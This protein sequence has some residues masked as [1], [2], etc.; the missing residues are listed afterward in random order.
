[1]KDR[2]EEI[3]S[4]GGFEGGSGE[5]V[6]GGGYPWRAARSVGGVTFIS[7]LGA[8][9]GLVSNALVAYHFGAG[10]LTDAFFLA[11]S[12]PL[13]L[14][15]LLQSGPLPSVFLPVFLRVRKEV[16]AEASWRLLSSLLN[17]VLLLD[18]GV[19][20]LG[21]FLAPWIVR[22]VGAGF[23]EATWAMSVRVL[24]FLIFTLVAHTL[25]GVLVIS[26]NALNRFVLPAAFSLLPSLGVVLFVGTLAPSMGLDAWIL[27]NLAGPAAFL[28]ALGLALVR[29]GYRYR[30]VLDLRQPEFLETVRRV[31]QFFI[32]SAFTQGQVLSTK[33][34]ASLLAPGSLSALAYAERIFLAASALFTIPLPNVVFPE[35]VRRKVA[36]RLD[37]LRELLFQASR[38]LVLILLPIS[39]GMMTIG[40]LVVGLLLQRGAFGAEDA[41]RTTWSLVLYSTALVPLGYKMLFTNTQHAFGRTRVVVLGLCAAQGTIIVGNFLF[42]WLFDYLGIPIAHALGQLVL[43]GVHVHFLKGSFPLKGI[44]WSPSSRRS[45]TAAVLMGAAALLFQWFWPAG[46]PTA[47]WKAS[48]LMGAVGVSGVVYAGLVFGLGVPEVQGVV[49]QVRARLNRRASGPAA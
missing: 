32:S 29:H 11:Q 5:D 15:H 27:G 7:G 47:L 38:A 19:A 26:L 48:V 34:V 42:A 40:G 6:E 43:I 13:V 22:A 2:P 4:A 24:R 8:V 9:L 33:F 28:L 17:F 18:V 41:V 30:P 16:S 45:L 31:C 10:R 46:E 44:F 39:I 49:A 12:I 20:A 25:S 35:L 3:L 21:F 1:M 36:E 37:D 14:A 23:D